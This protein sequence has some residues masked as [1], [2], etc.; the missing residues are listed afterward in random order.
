MNFLGEMGLLKLLPL[1]M[2]LSV[3]AGPAW[4]GLEASASPA[5]PSCS[6]A[7]SGKACCC[8]P[9]AQPKAQGCACQN[10]PS[11]Q[12]QSQDWLPVPHG[13]GQ[14]LLPRAAGD[15]PPPP[16]LAAAGPGHALPAWRPPQP[17]YLRLAS[18]LI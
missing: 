8:C 13:I 10:Q 6:M 2:C 15:S 4:W 5:K 17:I 14:P 16:T 7:K 1:L 18:L 12:A 3:L 11:P 9:Q